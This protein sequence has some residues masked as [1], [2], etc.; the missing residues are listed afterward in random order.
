MQL[1]VLDRG[2]E[3]KELKAQGS[4]VGILGLGFR[5]LGFRV[6]V[7]GFWG[8][9][10]RGFRLLFRIQGARLVCEPCGEGRVFRV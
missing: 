8:L 7:L 2:C 1:Q 9:G 6:S 10:L 4:G 3:L 5:V